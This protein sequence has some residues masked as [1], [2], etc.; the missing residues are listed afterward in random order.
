MS[1]SGS[2][3]RAVARGHRLL[4]VGVFLLAAQL[5][6]V[7]AFGDCII[8]G[9]GGTCALATN[10]YTATPATNVTFA[11]DLITTNTCGLSILR[12]YQ[13][14]NS[15]GEATNC[16]QLIIVANTNLPFISCASNLTV[17][18]GSAWDFQPP[19]ATDFCGST[20]LAIS[21]S[22][23]T[24][25]LVGITFSATRTW[26][27]TDTCSNT[28][29]CSQTTTLTD[30]TPP[31]ITC[32]TNMNVAEAPRDSGFA[33]VTFPTPVASDTCDNNVLVYCT[34]PS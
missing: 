28:P 26:T 23:I 5:L 11:G 34:P 6:Q 2:F 1:L 17:E 33:T 13:A 19:T 22:T 20:N 3:A 24:N 12:S 7:N 21:V 16:T 15:C 25:P 9:P 32:P 18:C 10:T 8:N 27:A 31:H 14:V 29:S 30:T 4:P